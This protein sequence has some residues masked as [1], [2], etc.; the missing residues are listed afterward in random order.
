MS[1]RA[2]EL[3]DQLRDILQR[4]HRVPTTNNLSERL[5]RLFKRKFKQV[6]TFRSFEN[7]GYI[8][9]GVGVI[10]V[11]RMQGRNLFSSVSEIFG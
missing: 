3:A 4:I 2:D 10:A 8:C 7:L 1:R 6:M 5:L 11:L 9:D